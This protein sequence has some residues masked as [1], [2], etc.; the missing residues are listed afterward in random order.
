VVSRSILVDL[1]ISLVGLLL[2]GRY[3]SGHGVGV[4]LCLLLFL[5]QGSEGKCH[6]M[7][8]YWRNK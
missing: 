4:C 2:V 8:S 6:E 7:D 5:G 1:S 3:G